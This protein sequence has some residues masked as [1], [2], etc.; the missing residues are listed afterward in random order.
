MKRRKIELSSTRRG[1]LLLVLRLLLL[2]AD[3]GARVAERREGDSPV[4]MAWRRRRARARRGAAGRGCCGCGA[5]FSFSVYPRE[6]ERA[7]SA[8]RGAFQPSRLVRRIGPN[9]STSPR[10]RSPERPARSAA[11]RAA[12]ASAYL[13]EP[14]IRPAGYSSALPPRSVSQCIRSRK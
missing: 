3:K 8:R 6:R 1:A 4:R 7:G 9:A 12:L 10:P 5:K 14:P 11:P 2:E 13:P